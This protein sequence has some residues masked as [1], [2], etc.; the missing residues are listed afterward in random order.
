[1]RVTR[2]AMGFKL[3][4]EGRAQHPAL[5]DAACA[6]FGVD[7]TF[8][9]NRN[10]RVR[11]GGRLHHRKCVR[12]AWMQQR[13]SSVPTPTLGTRTTSCTVLS[14]EDH[15]ASGMLMGRPKYTARIENI[16]FL[17]RIGETLR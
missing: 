4:Y 9:E 8:N 2:D 11:S 1:M 7:D 13:P 15:R 16:Y 10:S 6:W 14:A 17:R 5:D 12:V 3:I